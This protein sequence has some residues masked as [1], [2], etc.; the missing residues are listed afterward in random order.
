MIFSP[1]WSYF[2]GILVIFGIILPLWG[3][4]FWKN[5]LDPM[6]KAIFPTF[7]QNFGDFRDNFAFLTWIFHFYGRLH[8]I[9]AIFSPFWSYFRGIFHFE[10]IIVRKNTLNPMKKAIFTTFFP[11]IEAIFGIILLFWHEIFRFYTRLHI[12]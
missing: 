11:I 6:K 3:C 1:F 9:W 12:I 7:L 8:I 4:D 10:A 2:R 5:T